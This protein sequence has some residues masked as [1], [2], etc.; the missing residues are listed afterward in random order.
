MRRI[1]DRDDY[2][3]VGEPFPPQGPHHLLAAAICF[4]IAAAAGLGLW[5]S[6]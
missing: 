4:A 3:D 1:D 6:L 2:Q 5:W